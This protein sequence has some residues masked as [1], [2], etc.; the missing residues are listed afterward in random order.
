MGNQAIILVIGTLLLVGIL[1]G[2]WMRA[3]N[4]L[5]ANSTQRYT[6]SVAREINSSA[7]ET[8][9]R[10]LA[11]S[12]KWRSTLSNMSLY[13]GS[14]TV[15]FKDTLVGTDS[16]V[17]LRSSS[18]FSVGSDSSSSAA[19]VVVTGAGFVPHVV[20]GA[21]TAFGPLDNTLSDMIIDGR[22]WNF[23]ALTITPTS[24]KY[25][26]STGAAVFVNT[27]LAL[28]GGTTQ[29]PSPQV[30]IVP[31]FPNSPF[32][33]ETNSNW[34]GGWPNTPDKALGYPDGTLKQM[35]I[36][37]ALVGSQY[38]TD[39]SQLTFPV[40]G[41]TYLDVPNGTYINR[42]NLGM[43]PEGIIVLH[44]PNST[45]FWEWLLTDTSGVTVSGPIKGLLIFDKLHHIHTDILGSLVLLSPV[46]EG[47]HCAGNAG[48]YIRYSEETIKK[49]TAAS[50]VADA[51]WKSRLKVLSWYE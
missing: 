13:G 45:A 26:V 6:G 29:P 21:I 42:K 35:A 32:V 31:A 9:L 37:K 28:L 15:T 10:V 24:G 30:D 27:Q 5:T 17:V 25:A 33:V 12:L 18:K 11:D 34:P 2:A 38:V 39:Y 22:N 50:G 40:R 1:A 19:Q 47:L 44:S 43:N 20:R 3:G 7:V 36:T 16:A 48:H 46:T 51:S 49:F 14:A 41:I 4:D 8:A 23:D